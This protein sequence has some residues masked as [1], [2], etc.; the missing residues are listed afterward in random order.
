MDP[1]RSRGGI[2]LTL[3]ALTALAFVSPALAGNG[4]GGPSGGPGGGGGGGGGG[5]TETEGSNLST[6]VIWAEGVDLLADVT[7]RFDGASVCGYVGAN[8]TVVQTD[9]ALVDDV[10]VFRW[11]LQRDALSRWQASNVAPV[12][13]VNL[14]SVDWG[15]NLESKNWGAT[16]PV[17]TE[18]VLMQDV[19]GSGMF[20]YRMAHISGK[21]PT[22]VRATNGQTYTLTPGV[23]PPALWATV[24]SPCPR[25]TIQ[26]VGSYDAVTPSLVWNDTAGLWRFPG[27]STPVVRV[28][29]SG[30]SYVPEVNV[31]GKLIYGYNWQTRNDGLGL[32][33]LTFHLDQRY[34]APTLNTF[35]TPE[36]TV[37]VTAGESESHEGGRGGTPVISPSDN[38]TYIDVR[39]VPGAGGGGG[40][41]RR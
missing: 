6:P 29:L 41:G 15:D 38:L 17:R 7:T 27:G 18:V 33:R 39:I 25:Y 21:G 16:S 32:Y 19:T 3:M 2:V 22:E 28:D 36:T 37:W 8:G 24:Y 35:F 40:G 34:C 30:S 31:S 13:A 4:P 11:Y 26:R 20:G 1:R 14:T 12:A 5:H 9:C 10:S 23:A